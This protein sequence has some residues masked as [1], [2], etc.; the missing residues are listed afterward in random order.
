M[1]K[2]FNQYQNEN[3][4]I[5]FKIIRFGNILY[6]TGSV[7][8][9]WKNSI[10]NGEDIT[11]SNGESTRFFMNIEQTIN[12]IYECLNSTNILYIPD[13][14]SMSLQYLLEAMI[15]KYSSN[16]KKININM[17]VL[18]EGENNHEKLNENGPYSNEVEQYT[19]EEILN[20]I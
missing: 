2:L 10:L 13:I 5:K 17:A 9:K 14:K 11:L 15:I 7:S 12:S 8:Y 3:P 6:S 4:N 1:E 18:R 16:N 19:V 20:I